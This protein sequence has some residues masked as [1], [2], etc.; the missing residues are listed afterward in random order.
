M[1]KV[2]VL[3]FALIASLFIVS[4]AFAYSDGLSPE[5]SL[6]AEIVDMID[7]P[8]GS[9]L[10]GQNLVAN[11]RLMVNNENELIVIDTGTTDPKLDTFLKSKLNYKKVHS[12]SIQHFNFYFIKVEF[13]GK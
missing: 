10:D 9:I 5:S 8:G 13:R 1:R 11:L 4:T 6:R 7:H 12:P 3:F 2:K